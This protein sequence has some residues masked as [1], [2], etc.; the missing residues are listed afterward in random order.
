VQERFDPKKKVLSDIKALDRKDLE[1]MIKGLWVMSV[2]NKD[3][4]RSRIT[5]FR[6]NENVAP[7]VAEFKALINREFDMS[8]NAAPLR[9][10]KARKAIRDYEA[11][12]GDGHGTLD[13]LV[14][15]V[16]RGTKF[17]NSYG[18]IDERFYNHLESA[19]E[20]AVGRLSI[21]PARAWHAEFLPRLSAVVDAASD[22]GW[23][24]GDTLEQLFGRL[25]RGK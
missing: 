2:E 22:T 7:A 13:L 18:D 25:R 24:Y 17:T 3:F 8:H 19:F 16:E 6:G 10:E 1:Y 14:H 21:P 5:A 9:L 11:I 23:G 4:I 12:T 15:L 20:E